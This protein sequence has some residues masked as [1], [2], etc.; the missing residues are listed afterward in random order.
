MPSYSYP[1]LGQS[2]F[3]TEK[4]R[5]TAA[6]KE[7]G[8]RRGRIRLPRSGVERREGERVAEEEEK[9]L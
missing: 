4:E 5:E 2:G 7:G 8:E 1:H 3:E 9:A 6:V